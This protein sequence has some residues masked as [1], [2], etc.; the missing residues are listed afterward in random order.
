MAK[1]RTSI[2]TKVVIVFLLATIAVGG[3]GWVAYN[4]LN[5]LL[6]AFY[7]ESQPDEKLKT[8]ET[9]LDGLT[10]AENSVRAFTITQDAT[11][12]N[13]Y[14][15][16]I[17]DI[18]LKVEK[19]QALSLGDS[20][21]LKQIDTIEALIEKKFVILNNLIAVKND[22][23][24]RAVLEKVKKNIALAEEKEQT[25]P[26]MERKE[27]GLFE[28]IFKKEEEVK[29]V[30]PDNTPKLDAEEIREAVTEIEK[31][32]KITSHR[33][34]IR[35]LA[36]FNEDRVVTMRLREL[37]EEMEEKEL[38]LSRKRAA[39]ASENTA[40]TIA[41]IQIICIAAFILLLLLIYV[42]FIDITRS[43]IYRKNLQ[44]AK[45]KAEKLALAKEEFL[46]NMSHE[47]R[48]PLNSIIGFTEQ[49]DQT[50][51][52]RGQKGFLNVIKNSSEHLLVLIND[53]LDYAK[54]ETGKLSLERIPFRP[55]EV[56][57]ETHESLFYKATEKGVAFQY[58][59][60]DNI[61]DVLVG[62]PVRLK[63]ILLNLINNA[64]KFTEAGKV[65]V[66]GSAEVIDRENV[67]V[68]ISV[69]DT[70]IGIPEEKSRDIFRSFDQLDNS[71]TRKYGGTGLGLAI[72][73]KLVEMQ[74]GKIE[75]SSQV[76]QGTTISFSIPY[77]VGRATQLKRSRTKPLNLHALKGLNILVVDDEEYNLLLVKSILE[78]LK[79]NT[80]T[81]RSG[82]E[83]ISCLQSKR[84][85]MVLMDIQ[86]PEM[87][88][89]ETTRYIRE[90][91]KN[92]KASVPII[93]L[94]AGVAKDEAEMC[95]R[96]GM[97]E[98][99]LKPFKEYELYH[100]I[101]KVLYREV[102]RPRLDSGGDNMKN[103]GTEDYDLKELNNLA[104]GDTGFIISMIEIFIENA[105][106]GMVSIMEGIK[107]E[108]WEKVGNK[109]HKICPSFSHMGLKN[110]ARTLR[111][112]EDIA[113]EKNGTHR[114]QAMAQKL[115]SQTQAVI[116]KLEKEKEMLKHQPH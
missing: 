45:D 113:L 43:N 28:K 101:I 47:I 20:V 42:L 22:D 57:R 82:K 7:I 75:V 21:Q 9:I 11:Y 97:D 67:R 86:M 89:I 27:L 115:S 8:L 15:N 5:R 31:E 110:M 37:L 92:G 106:T 44:L 102:T 23:R 49:L 18:D 76:N 105:S 19:L 104:N 55:E 39:E 112:I 81:A 90:H 109:A 1:P 36:Y 111:E 41:I 17:S 93:A 2:K 14:Y 68:I 53:I 94:T 83:A 10:S 34:A 66:K 72:T 51:M 114:L 48:T 71:V 33:H 46:S 16:T 84:F 29:T 69:I 103:G 38:V 116:R 4:S 60:A 6:E 12:L 63:Q 78:K 58:T 88:G 13:P 62:D 70:G 95:H 99:I 32:E 59:M 30:D 100:K 73:K 91:F 77:K 107:E 3:V 79:V 50:T 108:N 61:P 40:Q 85:D 52:D 25:V 35:E 98:I 64:I 80:A 87:S 54:I 26:K 96:A 56:V 24:I 65:E 74:Q